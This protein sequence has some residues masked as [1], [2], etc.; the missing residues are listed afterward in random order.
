FDVDRGVAAAAV[1]P[2]A[3][4]LDSR[5]D[6]LPLGAR[7]M[8]AE[9]VEPARGRIEFG[10][11]PDEVQEVM[12]AGRL[13][14][15]HSVVGKCGLETEDVDVEALGAREIARLEGQMTEP[16][17]HHVS[18]GPTPLTRTS[19]RACRC[20]PPRCRCCPSSPRP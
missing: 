5:A 6:L 8:Q 3:G 15:D 17:V 9:V 18:T 12:P 2:H 11:R 1:D 7:E 10:P 19:G 4:V 20:P 16:A 13:E 14:E